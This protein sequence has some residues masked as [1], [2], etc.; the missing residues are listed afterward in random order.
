MLLFVANSGHAIINITIA[1][2][3]GDV[4]MTASGTAD[5]TGGEIFFLLNGQNAAEVG[6]DEAKARVGTFDAGITVYDTLIAG[7]TSFG[8]GMTTA[9]D[10]SSGSAVGLLYNGF[11]ERFYLNV[12][13]GYVSGDPLGTGTATWNSTTLAGLGITPGTYTYTWN[14]DSIVIN[15]A[16]PE[17]STYAALFGLAAVLVACRRRMR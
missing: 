4:V 16:V 14:T 17:P 7:P 3:G 11:V 5:L 13:V 1:E 9:A 2:S 12:P 15:A 10:A 8:T 6:P